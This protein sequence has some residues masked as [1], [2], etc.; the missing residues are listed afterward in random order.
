MYDAFKYMESRAEIGSL[1]DKYNIKDKQYILMTWHRQENTTSRAGMLH[2]LNIIQKVSCPI[3]FPIHPR[4][5]N[6]IEEFGLA[7]F[8]HEISNLKLIPPVGYAEMVALTKHSKLIIT[9]SGGLS[10]ESYFADVRCLFMADLKVWPELEEIGWIVHTTQDNEVNLEKYN[11][12]M[13]TEKMRKKPS[14]YGDG[15][16]AQKIVDLIENRLI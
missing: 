16:A 8:V 2:I 5:K 14:F 6:K 11:K 15:N 1:L 3:L 7:D 12:L 13:S 4:T 9:D 10:K